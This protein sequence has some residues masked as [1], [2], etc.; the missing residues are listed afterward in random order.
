MTSTDTGTDGRL[1]ALDDAE[2]WRHLASR[3]V[4]QVAY[5]DCGGPVVLPLN[6]TLHDG[7]F[8]GLTLA[9]G[10]R[11]IGSS[12]SDSFETRKNDDFVA[13]DLAVRYLRGSWEYAV[14]VTNVFAKVVLSSDGYSYNESGGRTVRASVG[15]HW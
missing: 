14:N 12:Y 3:T 7:A 13:C 2:C 11:Y 8:N 6:Y 9:A 5:V 15:Y 4:G 1:Q 10:V